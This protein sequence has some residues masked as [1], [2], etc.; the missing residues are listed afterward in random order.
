MYEKIQIKNNVKLLWF[1]SLKKVGLVEMLRKCTK[2]PLI[3]DINK[4]NNRTICKTWVNLN[5]SEKG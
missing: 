1:L 3:Y 5:F 2:R 4:N